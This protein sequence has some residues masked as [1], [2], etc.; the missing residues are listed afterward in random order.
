MMA[1]QR[2]LVMKTVNQGVAQPTGQ[3]Q[4]EQGKAYGAD[5]RSWH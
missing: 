5:E 4:E 3:R 1:G 2:L